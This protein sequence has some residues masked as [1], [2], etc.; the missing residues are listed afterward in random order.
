VSAPAS[1]KSQLGWTREIPFI[2]VIFP[3]VLRSNSNE[4][5]SDASVGRAAC[6]TTIKPGTILTCWKQ[7]CHVDPAVDLDRVTLSTVLRPRDGSKIY[8]TSSAGGI[9]EFDLVAL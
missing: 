2:L 7:M 8:R 3:Y 5:H 1:S 4:H 9:A 6:A